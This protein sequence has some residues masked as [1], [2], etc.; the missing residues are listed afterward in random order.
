[1]ADIGRKVQP[2]DF[3]V[4]KSSQLILGIP[5]EEFHEEM[6]SIKYCRTYLNSRE[7]RFI[8]YLMKEGSLIDA[9]KHS[10]FNVPCENVLSRKHIRIAIYRMAPLA[11]DPKISARMLSPLIT[12]QRLVIAMTNK[13]S[14]IAMRA[15]NDITDM[16]DRNEP[17]KNL[18]LHRVGSV[19]LPER[20]WA[21]PEQLTEIKIPALPEGVEPEEII[22]DLEKEQSSP[23]ETQP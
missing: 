23:S 18:H 1:M 6:S 12:Q 22:Q 4:D 8:K 2:T 20:P 10:G 13:S 3:P 21:R 5:I 19:T 9:H 11:V 17:K 15:M 16:G 14:S 7:R